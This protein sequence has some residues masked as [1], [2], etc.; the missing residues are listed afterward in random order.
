PSTRRPCSASVTA[1]RSPWRAINRRGPRRP[2]PSQPRD[3]IAPAKP[4]RERRDDRTLPR[5]DRALR[6]PPRPGRDGDRSIDGA[7]SGPLGPTPEAAL[8]RDGGRG[9]GPMIDPSPATT[10]LCVRHRG[11]VGMAGDGQ[12]TIGNP[13]VKAGARKVRKLYQARVLAGFA[14]AAA[15]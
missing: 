2:P 13:V 14:G 11:Q 12:V 3:R 4:A 5:D 15:D 10:V 1:A 9:T 6:P 8:A 7:L